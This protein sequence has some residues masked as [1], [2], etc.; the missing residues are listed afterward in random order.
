MS[1]APTI[2]K[3]DSRGSERR[4]CPREPLKWVVLV[5]FGEVNWG[6]L[7]DISESTLHSRPWAA[8]RSQRAERFS[9]VRSRQQARWYGCASLKE[10]RARS[11]SIWPKKAGNKFGAGFPPTLQSGPSHGATT[12]NW[13]SKRPNQNRSESCRFPLKRRSK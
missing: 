13:R 7:I 12:P 8:C 3:N 9:A 5:F 2:H 10:Q 11:L 1:C 6:K 4:S